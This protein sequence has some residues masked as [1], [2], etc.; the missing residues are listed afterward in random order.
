MPGSNADD[1]S[2][3]ILVYGLSADPIHVGH[4]EMATQSTRALERRGYHVVEVLLVPVYRRNPVGVAKERIP[5]T[6]AHRLAMCALAAGEIAVDLGLPTERVRASE[7]EAELVR[8]RSTPNYTAETLALLSARSEPGTG[9]IFLISS[10]L[11]SGPDPQLGRWYRPDEILRLAVLAICPRPGYAPNTT[12]IANLVEH[13]A[14]VV[15]LDEVATP[16]I[17]ASDIRALLR[18]GHSPEELGRKGMLTSAVA[19]YLRAHDVYGSARA[20]LEL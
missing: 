15:M 19:G 1:A 11:V 9:L 20:D 4:V 6:Y 14:R 18:A 13:G 3:H 10:E 17:S 12:F 8:D 5:D 16:E 2:A 7:I